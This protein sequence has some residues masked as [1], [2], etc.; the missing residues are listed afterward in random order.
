MFQLEEALRGKL[1]GLL[2]MI[3]AADINKNNKNNRL[4]SRWLFC[5]GSTVARPGV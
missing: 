3:I 2:L 4:L 1:N 5:Y